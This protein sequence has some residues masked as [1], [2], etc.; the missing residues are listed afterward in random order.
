MHVNMK[1][2][3]LILLTCRIAIL[4]TSYTHKQ[5]HNLCSHVHLELQL[6]VPITHSHFQNLEKCAPFMFWF[7]Y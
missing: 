1:H 6:L 5:L 7:M 2:K 3:V 4:Y